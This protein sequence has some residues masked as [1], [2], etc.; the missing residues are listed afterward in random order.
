MQSRMK[1][2]LR[3]GLSRPTLLGALALIAV[4]LV[5]APVWA[6][7]EEEEASPTVA[8]PNLDGPD[9]WIPSLSIG[10]LMHVQDQ[11]AR[12][13]S[14]L[15]ANSANSTTD[16]LASPGF[17][18]DVSLATPAL[19]ESE[20]EPRIFAQVGAQVILEE[21]FTAY[22]SID[23][24]SPGLSP[25]VPSA[26]IGANCGISEN[27]FD[28]ITGCTIRNRVE[29]QINSQWYV[30]TGFQIVIPAWQRQVRLRTAVDYL[31][32]SFSMTGTTSRDIQ[33]R[34]ETVYSSPVS[35]STTHAVGASLQGDALVYRW[36]DLRVSLF[37]ETRFAWIVS[38][39]QQV[40]STVDSDPANLTTYSIEPDPFIAQGGGGIR[41]SW[42]PNW[43]W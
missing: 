25:P 22:R 6:D 4:A 2:W 14:G 42:L 10:F 35:S 9:L 37:L 29:T 41:F 11:D 3:G 21:E 40:F 39:G 20:L 38:G 36:R 17:R 8:E 16:G 31:G 34:G 5:C 18:F 7:E 30:G 12:V 28:P 32:Q 19:F 26:V 13:I 24:Y 15:G 43:T 27:P 23:S 1:R 33:G